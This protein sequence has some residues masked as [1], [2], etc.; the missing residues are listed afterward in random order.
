M[1]LD[2]FELQLAFYKTDEGNYTGNSTDSARYSYDIVQS[3]QRELGSVGVQEPRTNEEIN[4]FNDSQQN[5]LGAL[6]TAGSLFTYVDFAF[7][8]N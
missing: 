7:G 4:Q 3:D 2:D 5:V 6:V 1:P 8:K